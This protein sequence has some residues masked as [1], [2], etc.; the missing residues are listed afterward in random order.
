MASNSLLNLS[1]SLGFNQSLYHNVSFSQLSYLNQHTLSL[2]Y[3]L[4]QLLE[5]S[6]VKDY[7]DIKYLPSAALFLFAI[8][9]LYT[10][11]YAS[12]TKPKNAEEPNPHHPLFDPSDVDQVNS[13]DEINSI[14]EKNAF[15]MPLVSGTVLVGLNYSLKNFSKD[16][17][18]SF[19]NQYVLFVSVF[20]N[21][22]TLS[23][24]LKTANRILTHK[25]KINLLDFLGKYRLTL[26]LDR[27]VNG[28]GADVNDE[29]IEEENQK[30]YEAILKLFGLKLASKKPKSPKKLSQ[31]E[32]K[33]K[34]KRDKIITVVEKD[35]QLVNIFFSSAETIAFPLAVIAAYVYSTN[36]GSQNWILSTIFGLSFSIFGIK[37]A[38]INSFKTGLILLT[39]LFFYDIYF[40][41]KSDIMVNVATG[42]DIPA[43]LTF[44]SLPVTPLDPA[45]YAPKL[46]ASLLGLGDIVV[47]GMFVSL[48]LRYDLFK[49][50]EANPK[51]EFHHLNKYPKTY[52][53]SAFTGYVVG[54][55]A[56]MF[57]LHY[58]KTGQPALLYLCPS[59]ILFTFTTALVKGE[60]KTLLKF[61]EE[62]K[63]EELEQ[64]KN[65]INESSKEPEDKI[66]DVSTPKTWDAFLKYDLPDEG[67]DD[68]ETYVL[69]AAQE[70]DEAD[71]TEFSDEDL[72][73]EESDDDDEY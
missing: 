5:T 59:I 66:G 21:Y 64:S 25:L 40:V 42:L 47:P 8:L 72:E 14:K 29:K 3:A 11:S 56:T 39:G 57:S 16:S 28:T 69:T 9:L 50:H 65:V 52:F 43:K 53:T 32:K 4:Y 22:N 24:F 73:D 55:L 51:T 38:K 54:L 61:S 15:L 58:F 70:I 19:L 33:I 13:L 18:L 36:N 44:P 60:V 71:D 63:D 17:I 49:Y 67:E 62:E 37:S 45:S 31:R 68:D 48:C 23:Y 2:T 12:I 20:A 34:A 41:F 26:S 30:F 10:G 6:G 1:V 7:V 27:N 35:D 46:N